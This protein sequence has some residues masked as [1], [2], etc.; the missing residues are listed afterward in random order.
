MTYTLVAD[1]RFPG[2]AGE[3]LTAAFL[4]A[5]H[6]TNNGGSAAFTEVGSAGQWEIVLTVPD[7][8]QGW[9]R[10]LS[11]ATVLDTK[12]LDPR[13]VE[14]ADILSSTIATGGLDLGD[15]PADVWAYA[16]RTLTSAGTVTIVSPWRAD[17][18]L[19]LVE[20]AAYTAALG[21]RLPA[22]QLD[23]AAPDWSVADSLD[24]D[25]GIRGAP[26]K[27]STAVELSGPA[28]A[29]VLQIGDIT[30]LDTGEL[31]AGTAYWFTIWA[32]LDDDRAVVVEGPCVVEGSA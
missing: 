25:I 18:T 2:H 6:T 29:Q 22:L 19:E 10:I 23:S 15:I 24:C 31:T 14:N 8:F 28:S 30:S 20:G 5:N 3:T 1:A 4:N 21:T 17:G 16:S 27:F 26:P 32:S 7:A 9:V 13:E 11:G 12:A